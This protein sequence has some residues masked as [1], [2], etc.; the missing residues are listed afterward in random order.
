MPQR[1]VGRHE[2]RPLTDAGARQDVVLLGLLLAAIGD[3]ARHEDADLV[4]DPAQPAVAGPE[5][6]FGEAARRDGG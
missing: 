6:D 2:L 4:G 1:V 5:A 3:E